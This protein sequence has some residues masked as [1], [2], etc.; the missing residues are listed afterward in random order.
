ME[1]LAE[2]IRVVLR[3][4]AEISGAYS[5][6]ISQGLMALTQRPIGSL[7]DA[8]GVFVTA[9]EISRD[10]AGVVAGAIGLEVSRTSGENQ[11]KWARRWAVSV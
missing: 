9:R 11:T 8:Y 7:E 2:E 10:C 3:H 5:P 6:E 4:H 1:E